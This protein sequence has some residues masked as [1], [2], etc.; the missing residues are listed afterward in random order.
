MEQKDTRDKNHYFDDTTIGNYL[1]EYATQLKDVLFKVDRDNM[2]KTVSLLKNASLLGLP[3]FVAGNGGSSA[4]SDHLECDFEKGVH[5]NGQTILINNLCSNK[6]LMT[7]IG[8]DI[9]F[10]EI[11]SKRL[12]MEAPP[13][14]SVLIL[15]SSSGNSPNIIK[16]CEYALL[17]QMIIIGLT[18]FDGG[19]LKKCSHL[20][21]HVPANNYG[22]IEDAHQAIMH[23]LAQV[24]FLRQKPV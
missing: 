18:G 10:E 13:K 11:F 5:K 3:I 16:A 15:V 6:A 23:V 7:A 24:S 19:E 21:L 14:G 9:G 20:S 12:E 2:D 22:V 4:I 8:N 17:H 1:M